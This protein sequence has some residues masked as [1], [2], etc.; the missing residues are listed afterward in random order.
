[1]GQ[2]Q[3]ADGNP[4][5]VDSND[6][7]IHSGIDAMTKPKAPPPPAQPVDVVH[8]SAGLI[9]WVAGFFAALFAA[10][11]GYFAIWDRVDAHWLTTN[12]FKQHQSTDG[13]KFAWIIFS[14][15]DFRAAAA[16]KW[17]E[18]CRNQKR[19]ESE[20][21]RLEREANSLTQQALD[22]KKEAAATTKEKAE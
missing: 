22:L 15:Q 11:V 7:F 2:C 1:M 18:D 21:A 6:Y 9:K 4:A 5:A 8:V 13:Q 3:D 10:I 16:A 12:K 19:P 14:I 17:A 20:C